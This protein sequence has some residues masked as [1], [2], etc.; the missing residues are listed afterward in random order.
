MPLPPPCLGCAMALLTSYREN[1]GV[2]SINTSL[3]RP[4][5]FSRDLLSFP[6]RPWSGRGRLSSPG[7]VQAAQHTCFLPRGW[8]LVLQPHFRESA[9]T[10]PPPAQE[11]LVLHTGMD[12]VCPG[13]C[14]RR[15]RAGRRLAAAP[16]EGRVCATWG[17]QTGRG[18]YVCSVKPCPVGLTP[19]PG[20]VGFQPGAGLEL[21]CLALRT[22]ALGLS[23]PDVGALRPRQS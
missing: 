2:F 15:E 21:R 8:P 18:G 19:C 20:T 9:V 5:L 7:R 3:W 22:L 23:C 6:C 4:W 13:G 17:P 14:T 11:A 16:Q 10:T 1:L 12:A